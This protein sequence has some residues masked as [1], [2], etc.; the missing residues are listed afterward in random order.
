MPPSKPRLLWGYPL[1]L[2]SALLVVAGSAV[3]LKLMAAYED[4]H[5]PAAAPPD[6]CAAIGPALFER[7]VPF[8]APQAESIYSSGSDA[9]SDYT[10]AD[11]KPVGSA[12]RASAIHSSLRF[13]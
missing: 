10:T 13:L 6:L 8:G 12:R 5:P 2:T 4:A 11:S 1:P 3:Y 7:L 9:S